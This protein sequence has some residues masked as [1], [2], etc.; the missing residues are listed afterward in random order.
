[1]P[2]TGHAECASRQMVWRTASAVCNADGAP[3]NTT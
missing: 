2:H 1:M 3:L